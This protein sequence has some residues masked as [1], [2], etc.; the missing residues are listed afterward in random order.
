MNARAHLRQDADVSSY[1]TLLRIGA[2]VT[3]CRLELE[4]DQADLAELVGVP[5]GTVEALEDRRYDPRL[6]LIPHLET[7]LAMTLG[8]IEQLSPDD[9]DPRTSRTPNCRDRRRWPQ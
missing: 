7:G 9:T 2:A 3:I 8:T 6:I 1:W 5:A 4:L